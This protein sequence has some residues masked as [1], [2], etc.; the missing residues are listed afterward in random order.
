M[1]PPSIVPIVYGISNPIRFNP[2]IK[3]APPIIPITR[4]NAKSPIIVPARIAGLPFAF[5]IK[6]VI[7]L[8]LLNLFV[9]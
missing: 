8:M 2:K 3:I 6:S 7:A 1:A 4:T 5:P 9:D